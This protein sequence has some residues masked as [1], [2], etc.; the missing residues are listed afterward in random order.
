MLFSFPVVLFP[1]VHIKLQ[2]HDDDSDLT[3]KVKELGRMFEGGG[4]VFP[5]TAKNDETD[6]GRCLFAF[7]I[8]WNLK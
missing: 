2:G 4:P 8:Q 7:E 5:K 3:G 1:E 6:A